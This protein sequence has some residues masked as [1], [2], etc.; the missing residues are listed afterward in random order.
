M[1]EEEDDE[2]VKVDDG[3]EVWEIGGVGS[4]EEETENVEWNRGEES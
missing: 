3:D 1:G 2:W 4:L